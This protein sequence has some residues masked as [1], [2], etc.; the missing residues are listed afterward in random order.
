MHEHIL[1]GQTVCKVCALVGLKSTV[2]LSIKYL[3]TIFLKRRTD[4]ERSTGGN[5]FH[6]RGKQ[7]EN[8]WR[9][10]DQV[11]GECTNLF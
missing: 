6:R 8:V 5:E 3:V 11:R 2:N 1:Q 9:A 10:E 7:S 4:N